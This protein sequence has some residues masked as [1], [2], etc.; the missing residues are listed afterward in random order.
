MGETSLRHPG[1]TGVTLRNRGLI[2]K[3]RLMHSQVVVQVLREN[4]KN[5]AAFRG[6]FARRKREARQ[7]PRESIR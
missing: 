4:N 3:S 7:D 6:F 2:E 5:H 1:L